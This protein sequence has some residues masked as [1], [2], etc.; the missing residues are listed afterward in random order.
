MVI[1]EFDPKLVLAVIP[2]WTYW[3]AFEQEFFNGTTLKFVL[4]QPASKKLHE[5]DCVFELSGV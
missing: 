2:I 5:A 4:L 3:V 1:D